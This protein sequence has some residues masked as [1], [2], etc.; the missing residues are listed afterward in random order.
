[1]G[2]VRAN[3]PHSF[4]FHEKVLFMRNTFYL[5]KA[6][7][8]WEVNLFFNGLLEGA[9]WQSWRQELSGCLCSSSSFCS[10]AMHAL[11]FGLLRVMASCVVWTIGTAKTGWELKGMRCALLTLG[12]NIVHCCIYFCMELIVAQSCHACHSGGSPCLCPTVLSIGC[13]WSSEELLLRVGFTPV[14]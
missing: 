4:E 12:K 1:M 14:P 13:H 5:W 6:L 10:C 11:T 7:K 3:R 9:D 8:L 2:W